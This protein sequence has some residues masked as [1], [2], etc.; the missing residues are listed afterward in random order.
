MKTPRAPVARAEINKHAA[1]ALERVSKE[2]REKRISRFYGIRAKERV[3]AAAVCLRS[4]ATQIIE[5][6]RRKTPDIVRQVDCDIHVAALRTYLRNRGCVRIGGGT[7]TE[8]GAAERLLKEAA[9]VDEGT[10]RL[11]VEYVYSQTGRDLYEAGHVTASREYARGPDPFKW[12][13]EM[14]NAALH[15]RAYGF[16]DSAA[17]ARIRAAMVPEGRETTTTFLTHR[18][19]IFEAFGSHL[20]PDE[21]QAVRRKRMKATTNAYDMDA[22]AGIWERRFGNPRGRTLRGV[23]KTLSD[24]TKFSMEAYQKAQ[25]GST[26]WLWIQAGGALWSFMK[27]SYQQDERKRRL[28]WKSYVLQEAEACARE[29]KMAWAARAGIRVMNLQHDGI[30]TGSLGGRQSQEVAR[31]MQ[32]AASH[33]CGHEVQVKGE[34]IWCNAAEDAS[35]PVCSLGWRGGWEQ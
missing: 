24:G 29:A 35:A 22:S 9:Y 21:A 3:R 5:I 23:T 11:R 17:Y 1:E 28:R 26:D 16:D 34:L 6:R 13:E 7:T 19:E 25:E 10:A 8:R 15:D 27:R 2:M 32:E 30:V 12:P 4:A 20:W 33:A 18:E 14:R 31:G